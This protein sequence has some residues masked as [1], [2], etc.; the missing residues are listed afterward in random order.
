MP[1]KNVNIFAK[2]AKKV[3]S[4]NTFPSNLIKIPE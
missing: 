4:L 2:D 3:V 1:L